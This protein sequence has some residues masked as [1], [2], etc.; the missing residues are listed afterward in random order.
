MSALVPLPQQCVTQ[1]D[2]TPAM[3]NWMLGTQTDAIGFD[4]SITDIGARLA[5]VRR[6]N[7]LIDGECQVAQGAAATLTTA[8][9]YALVDMWAAWASGGAVTAG[10]IT[11]SV[12]VA[13]MST[14]YA[15]AVAGVTLTGSGQISIRQRIE[16]KRARDLVNDTASFSCAVRH[17]NAAAVPVVVVIRKANAV[18]S[19]GGTTVINTS[20]P[21]NAAVGGIT[22]IAVENVAMGNCGNGIEVEVQLQMGACTGSF[23]QFADAQ[24]VQGSTAPAFVPTPFDDALRAVQR[25]FQ[26]SFPYATAPASASGIQIGM[27]TRY[28]IQAGAV[29]SGAYLPL[30]GRMRAQPTLTFFN[31]I[32]N[33]ANWRNFT[34]GTDSGAA[35]GTA[36]G[37]QATTVSHTQVAGDAVGNQCGIHWTADARL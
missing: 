11:Q 29:L 24:L 2:I 28:A 7:L 1:G 20:A 5:L 13:G 12:A 4:N 22:T 35:G 8:A 15:L 19:F 37:E 3:R 23:V 18:D 34:L 26:K 9:Q 30:A 25:Y 33:N 31:P 6:Q 36:I 32:S 16:S 27:L 17:G 14:Q 10:A 21:Q